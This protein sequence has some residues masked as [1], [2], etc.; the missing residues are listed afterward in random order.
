MFRV[1]PVQLIASVSCGISSFILR[2]HRRLSSTAWLPILPRF[3]VNVIRRRGFLEAVH[4]LRG[5]AGVNCDFSFLTQWLST[6]TVTGVGREAEEDKVSLTL[7][8]KSLPF[9]FSA[10]LVEQG[11][12]V[13]H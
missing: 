10:T 11:K 6:F 12:N 2:L 7:M 4:L 13:T 8:C 1:V 5:A 3:P 9:F